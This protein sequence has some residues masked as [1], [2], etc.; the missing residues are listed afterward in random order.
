MSGSIRTSI[1]TRR[2]YDILHVLL[3]SHR[4]CE[5]CTVQDEI[6]AEVVKLQGQIRHAEAIHHKNQKRTKNDRKTP[7][8]HC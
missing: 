1:S 7:E 4:W 5:C 6:L 2:L 3:K 8:R